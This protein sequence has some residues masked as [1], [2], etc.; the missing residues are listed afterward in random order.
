MHMHQGIYLLLRD[1]VFKHQITVVAYFS[2]YCITKVYNR[3]TAIK[4]TYN[5]Y[6]IWNMLI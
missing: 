3:L 5:F 1:D 4:T 2:E 6:C